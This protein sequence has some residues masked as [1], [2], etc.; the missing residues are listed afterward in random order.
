MLDS[1][2]LVSFLILGTIGWVTYKLYIWP[3]YISPLRKIPGP[4][5]DNLLYGNIK[6][7][8]VDGVNICLLF[9]DSKDLTLNFYVYFFFLRRVI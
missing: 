5:S 3:Y 8:L 2:T 6:Q 1:S 4:P 9:F 7:F